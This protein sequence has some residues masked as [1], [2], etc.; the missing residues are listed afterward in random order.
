VRVDRL[1]DRLVVGHERLHVELLEAEH[2][3]VGEG[4]PHLGTEHADVPQGR[5]D[6]AEQQAAELLQG[7][8]LAHVA[9]AVLGVE[10]ERAPDLLAEE[11]V[12]HEVAGLDAELLALLPLP[13]REL[14]VVVAQGQ[15]PEGDVAGLVLHHVGVDRLGERVDGDV[16]DEPERRQRQPLDQHLHAEVGHVPAGVGDDVVQQRLQVGVDRVGEVQLVAQVA[17]VRLDVARLVHHL[18]GGVELGVEVGDGLDDLGGA[19]QRALLAVEELGELPGDHVVADLAPFPLAERRPGARAVDGDGLLGRQQR[20]VEVDL[21][22]PVD[23]LGRV[24]LPLLALVVEAEEPVAA[25]VVVPVEGGGAPARQ[26][27]AGVLDGQGVDARAHWGTPSGRL[28]P[29]YEPS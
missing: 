7:L 6:A 12:A 19:D 15:P 20:V 8:A 11:A 9:D 2:A 16:A 29:A 28:R 27:P 25:F 1:G 4:G 21:V 17:G 26:V 18:G 5:H 23:P 24:P 13:V 10:A 14:P 22:R 3:H